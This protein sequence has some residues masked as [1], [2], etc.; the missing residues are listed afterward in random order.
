MYRRVEDAQVDLLEMLKCSLFSG[1]NII[2]RW[3]EC[4]EKVRS[5]KC[6]KTSQTQ[7]EKKEK[8]RWPNRAVQLLLHILVRCGIVT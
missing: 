8:Q 4:R 1:L 6:Q 2:E 7:T 5:S 3:E